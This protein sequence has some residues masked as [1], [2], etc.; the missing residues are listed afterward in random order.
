M[1]DACSYCTMSSEGEEAGLCV[2]PD[3]ATQMKELN[4]D[5]DCTNIGLTLARTKFDK[6][7]FK[8]EIEG[9]NDADK[10]AST[11]T[12]GEESCEF[13]TIEGPFGTQGFCFSPD[14]AE[15]LE[16]VVG[17]KISCTSGLE[18]AS[19]KDVNGP[20]DSLK[21]TMEAKTDEDAC[22]TAIT[23]DGDACSY[24]TMS[25]EGEEAG[26]CVNPDVATQMTQLNPS[27]TCTNIG[28]KGPVTDCNIHGIDHDTCLDP[29]KV[30]GSEC[31]WCDA[32]I[33]G[34]CFPKAWESQ[35]GKFLSCEVPKEIDEVKIEEAEE[36]PLDIDP[37]FLKS[38]CFMVGLKGASPD[39]CRAAV[40]E[41]SG[42]NCIFCNAP[43]LGGIGLCMTPDF[44]GNEGQFYICDSDASLAVE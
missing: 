8:C 34:F 24:C 43:K 21:C 7:D 9:I 41:E 22:A 25:S 15:K 33:G 27:V 29:S 44:K 31:M 13:C 1:G 12:V 38:N 6:D 37:S 16:G 10:C 42:E 14:H 17:D 30:N 26:L 35:V 23:V 40:D 28:L 3:V 19:N 4:P 36:K 20:F 39:D 5:I 2:D 18:M 32:A 11:V